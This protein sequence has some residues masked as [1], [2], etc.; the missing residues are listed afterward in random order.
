MTGNTAT[1][2]WGG[3]ISN[4]DLGSTTNLTNCTIS[5]NTAA[6]GG[7][8]NNNGSTATVNLNY[9]TVAANT[10]SIDGGGLWQNTFGEVTNLKNSIVA[11]NTAA[12]AGPDIF[13]PITSQDYNHVESTTGGTFVALANDVT[14]SDP[15][16]GPLADNGGLTLS[17]L[18]GGAS[19]I[20]NTI[21]GSDCGTTVT[22][23]Q[24]GFPRPVGSGCEKGAVEVQLPLLISVVS[25]KTHGG[26]GIFDVNMP[27]T[28]TTGVE[29]RASGNGDHSLVFT[30]NNPV[31]SGSANVTEGMGSV[32]GSPT[33]SGQTM[34]VNLTDVANARPS[35]SR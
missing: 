17:H 2:G 19:P 3:G 25:R 35:P 33:F 5:G 11:D 14:G 31:N 24:R 18:P 8:I 22:V 13:G 28:G 20:L 34:T 4:R 29:C 1:S 30:F 9:S 26:A 16:L 23:D 7:G 6:R 27:L 32:A 12:A 21:T 15:V 10:A